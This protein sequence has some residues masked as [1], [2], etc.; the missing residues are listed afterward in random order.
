MTIIAVSGAA[1]VVDPVS[2]SLQVSHSNAGVTFG[3]MAVGF[4]VFVPLQNPPN[5]TERLSKIHVQCS[6]SNA[7]ISMIEI[8]FGRTLIYN[9]TSGLG[10]TDDFLLP[11]DISGNQPDLSV[12]INV[13]LFIE[14]NAATSTFT[15]SSLG[16]EFV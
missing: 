12:G 5:T 6:S 16:L 7:S 13:S 14:L 8:S 10:Y 1:A 4:T 11:V 15:L 2:P 3:G 9:S